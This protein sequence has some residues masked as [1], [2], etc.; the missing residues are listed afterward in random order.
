MSEKT[1]ALPPAQ[2]ADEIVAEIKAHGDDVRRLKSAG[3]DFSKALECLKAAKEK[4][5]DVT[6]KDF[7]VKPKSK[8]KKKKSKT[9]VEKTSSAAGGASASTYEPHYVAPDNSKLAPD[10]RGPPVQQDILKVEEKFYITTAINYTNGKPHIGHAYEAVTS[11]V[12]SRYHRIV[13]RDVYFLTGSDEHG[14]KVQNSAEAAGVQPIEIANKYSLG[15]QELNKMLNISNDRYVRTTEPQHEL[16]AQLMFQKADDNGDIYLKN[17]VGWYDVREERFVPDNEAEM[18]GFKDEHGRPLEKHNEESYHFRMSKYQDRLVQHIKDHPEFIQPEGQRNLMLK[19]L[20]EPLLDL[21]VSRPLSSLKWGIPLPKDPSHVMYVWFDALTNYLTGINYNEEDDSI[22]NQF[23]PCNVHIVGRDIMW[24]H[25]VIWP[26]MLMSAHI[27]LPKT[28]FGHGWVMAVNNDDNTLV[29]MSKSLGNVVDPVGVLGRFP[30]DTFRLYLVNEATYGEN[31]GFKMENLIE[32][33]NSQLVNTLGNLVNRVLKLLVQKF[34]S[35]VPNYPSL[36]ES[37]RPFNFSRLKA[38][39]EAHMVAFE[40]SRASNKIW[41][42]V[43]DMNKWLFVQEP[44]K[45]R[46]E[47][48]EAKTGPILRTAI[49]GLYIL[50][51]FLAPYIPEAVNAIEVKI[52]RRIGTLASIDE[53]WTNIPVG[54]PIDPRG[55][56][57]AKILTQAEGAKHAIVT[58][59]KKKKTDQG[60]AA[61]GTG[62]LF[63]QIDL[64]VGTVIKCWDHP[65]SEKMF[66]ED[67]DVGEAQ[68]LKVASSLRPY[69]TKEEFT[70]QKVIVVR[71]MKTAKLLGFKSQGM[72]LCAKGES[73]C[74]LI[75]P[76][77]GSTNGERVG[78]EGMKMIEPL[79]INQMKKQKALEKVLPHLSTGEGNTKAMYK[80]HSLT[81]SA[82]ICSAATLQGTPIC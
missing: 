38:E 31:M 59:S 21:S 5:K 56:L 71:N 17:Y 13:G 60:G 39:V 74:E 2:N 24:F 32:R 26:C 78:A 48:A 54:T 12:I 64:R 72:V 79:S 11:D 9:K 80:G 61:G 50:S 14:K 34:E 4:Y 37:E 6:G 20:E 58:S 28:I 53:S 35:K 63:E 10:T 73:G 76:C 62:D 25:C 69:Y 22:R 55:I 42:A 81:T 66:C 1:P 36:G 49:E 65:K 30:A 3:E 82:G 75:Q 45:I 18:N 15:F 29:K 19:R 27:P 33:H 70:G 51:H 41:D 40:L 8:K 57:F 43:R 47:G 23:W 67:I 68:P 77:D 46:G 44:W 7:G 52:H 16:M